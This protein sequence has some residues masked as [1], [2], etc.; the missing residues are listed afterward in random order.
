MEK[1]LRAKI[2]CSDEFRSELLSTDDK[3]LIEAREDL[4]WGSDLSYRITTTTNPTYHPG[5]SWLGEI[6]MK[7]RGDLIS[8]NDTNK[9][10]LS[11]K[12]DI[13]TNKCSL[14]E[15]RAL[16]RRGRPTHQTKGRSSENKLRNMSLSPCRIQSLKGAK[17]DTPL[18]KDFLRK[19]AKQTRSQS[20]SLDTIK[21][22]SIGD[23]S[24]IT[25][26]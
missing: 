22:V 18:L 24:Q 25:N 14:R 6:L 12:P 5:N 7:I 10:E 4:W 15:S 17:Y 11:S 9:Q 3:L 8:D 21:S 2:E 13:E 20:D 19:Q 1:V 16:S 23:D 26:L